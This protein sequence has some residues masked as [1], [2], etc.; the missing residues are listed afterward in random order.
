MLGYASQVYMPLSP[1]ISNV[2]HHDDEYKYS[3]E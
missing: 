2:M 3:E 1:Y